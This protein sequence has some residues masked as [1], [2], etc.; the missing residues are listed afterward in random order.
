MGIFLRTAL[1]FIFIGFAVYVHLNPSYSK[2][3]VDLR[4]KELYGRYIQETVLAK[5]VPGNLISS[6][7]TVFINVVVGILA[8]TGLCALFGFCFF[9]KLLAT[10]FIVLA[11]I[12]HV[13]FVLSSTE[14]AGEIRKLMFI[15][16]LG[17]AAAV[18][19]G[20]SCQHC[21]HKHGIAKAAQ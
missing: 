14:R 10:I 6:C 2:E 18:Y 8:T 15:V 20:S 12:L 4:Y 19:E 16:A 7:G 9:F 1:A 11:G 5:I 21:E 13:Q 3:Y 17:C